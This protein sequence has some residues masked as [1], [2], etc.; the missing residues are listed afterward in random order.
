MIRRGYKMIEDETLGILARVELEGL[1]YIGRVLKIAA[2][3][4]LRPHIL[5]MSAAKW[6]ERSVLDGVHVA[7][8]DNLCRRV[9][10]DHFSSVVNRHTQSI[11]HVNT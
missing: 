5:N 10:L 2:N 9:D 11:A 4:I 3:E 1:R 8:T 6:V 7:L